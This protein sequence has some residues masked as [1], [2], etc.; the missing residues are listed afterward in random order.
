MY[1]I[2]YNILSEKKNK[3]LSLLSQ[4]ITRLSLTLNHI[5]LSKRFEVLP[6]KYDFNLCQKIQNLVFPT[7]IEWDKKNEDYRTVSEN[8]AFEIF[9]SISMNYRNTENKK[10]PDFS[11][12]IGFVAE[13]GIE[14]E[15]KV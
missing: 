4:S 15:F 1:I 10:E 7:G 11:D 9:R 12:S 5:H 13:P 6:Q 14:P 2:L 3:L 8:K